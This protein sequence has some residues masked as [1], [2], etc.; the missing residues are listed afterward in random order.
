MTPP[1]DHPLGTQDSRL[2][3]TNGPNLSSRTWWDS[4]CQRCEQTKDQGVSKVSCHFLLFK[5]RVELTT[6]PLQCRVELRVGIEG[7]KIA[8]KSKNYNLV[9]RVIMKLYLSEEDTRVLIV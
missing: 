8:K 9:F 1:L 3:C 6:R 4:S 5:V 2:S 7:H